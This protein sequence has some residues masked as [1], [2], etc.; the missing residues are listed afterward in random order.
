MIDILFLNLAWEGH[1]RSV[2]AVAEAIRAEVAS[3]H[4]RGSGGGDRSRS[5]FRSAAPDSLPGWRS[6]S[7]LRLADKRLYAAKGGGRNTVV[8]EASHGVGCAA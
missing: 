1:G 3:I 5:P 2:A 6:E 8:V 7:V 4:L